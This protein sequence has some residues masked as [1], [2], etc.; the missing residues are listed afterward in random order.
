MGEQDEDVVAVIRCLR[1]DAS[2]FEVIVRRYQRVLFG[3]ARRMLG[4]HEDALDAAQNV[5]IRT[6]ERLETYD[7]ERRFF[8]WIYRIAVNECLNIRRARREAEPLGE[9][10][11]TALED[12]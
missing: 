8:S 2:A 10:F 9:E 12:P 11:Q 3:V 4:N 5:F 6:Y 7:P 1:G